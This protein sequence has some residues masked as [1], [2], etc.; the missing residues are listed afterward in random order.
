[1]VAG[2]ASLFRKPRL[3]WASPLVKPGQPQVEPRRSQRGSQRI[4]LFRPFLIL[5]ALTFLFLSDLA[6]SQIG[7]TD[8]WIEVQ[9]EHFRLLS[10]ASQRTTYKIGARLEQLRQVLADKLRGSAESP[11][12]TYIYVFKNEESFKPFKIGAN[13]QPSNVAGYYLSTPF[14]NYMAIDASAGEAPFR[15][16]YHEFVHY[17][18]HINMPYIPLW[19]NEGLAEYYSTFRVEGS[20]AQVGL[21]I[22][23]HRY[24]LAQHKRLPL[25]QL[26]MMDTDSPD[27]QEGARQGTF[28]AESWALAHY[29]TTIPGDKRWDKLL[30]EFRK[31]ARAEDAFRVAYAMDLV[32]L[33]KELTA[34]YTSRRFNYVDWNFDHNLEEGS[35]VAKPIERGEIN[36]YLGDLMANH[37][38]IQFD[39]AEKYIGAALAADSTAR[40]MASLGQLRHEQKRHLEAHQLFQRAV[41]MAPN[42]PSFRLR[43]GLSLLEEFFSPRKEHSLSVDVTPPLLLQAREHLRRCIELNAPGVEDEL[44]FA[45]TFLLDRGKVFEGMSALT[46]VVNREPWRLDAIRDL[47]VLT[48]HSGNSQA[49][50]SMLA[51]TLRPRGRQ[52]LVRYAEMAIANMDIREAEKLAKEERFDEAQ[53]LLEQTLSQ[54]QDKMV[55]GHV[56]AF[57]AQV[58]HASSS[59][60]S[61]KE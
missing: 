40:T 48:A 7:S 57:L 38:P 39:A 20:R 5:P 31:G 36:F 16:V 11:L 53:K 14:A 2:M 8:S 52:A 60:P 59:S 25:T 50:R 29:L 6:L 51:K 49:A 24:W 27:Y 41:E 21:P 46:S 10:N 26:F 3:A 17:F 55:R 35:P 33:E 34:A 45:R 4:A 42:D 18:I 58:Q 30:D 23:E 44:G 61:S 47:V 37:T 22:E 54:S 13:G 56:E 9:T 1:M 15:T 19:L 32:A 43:Y 12:P 28:Y